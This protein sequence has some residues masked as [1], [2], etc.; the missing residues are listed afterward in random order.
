MKRLLFFLVLP[1][2]YTSVFSQV[3]GAFSYQAVVRDASGGIMANQEIS[4][5]VSILQE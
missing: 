3:P 1:F 2:I 5:R 4:L